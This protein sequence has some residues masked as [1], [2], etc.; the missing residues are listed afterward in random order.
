MESATSIVSNRVHAVC[1]V[2]G[3]TQ[4][5]TRRQ[6]PGDVGECD[7]GGVTQTAFTSELV[8]R[9]LDLAE[10]TEAPSLRIWAGVNASNEQERAKANQPQDDWRTLACRQAGNQSQN[11][12][13]QRGYSQS[14]NPKILGIIVQADPVRQGFVQSDRH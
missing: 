1:S 7:S 12:Q 4:L 9:C 11:R 2:L 10:I 6:K 3:A 14:P 13:T 5:Q 8:F